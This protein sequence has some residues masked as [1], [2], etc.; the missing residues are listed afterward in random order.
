[1]AEMIITIAADVNDAVRGLDKVQSEI[2]QTGKSAAALSNSVSKAAGSFNRLPQSANQANQAITN[3]NR[4]VQDAPFGFVGIQ[5][6][7]G[8]LIDSF[9]QLKTTTG[10][11]GGALRALLGSLAG[12]AGIGLAIAGIT[13][14]LT[15]A[16]QGFSSWTRGLGAA[17][18]ANDKLAESL[19]LD[20]VRLTSIVG[21]A[22]NA[23]ASTED[24]AKA[25]KLLNQ[26]YAKYLPSLDK[27]AITLEN[28]SQKYQVLVDAMLRQA[29]VKGLQE[30]IA[31]QVEE[32]AKQVTALELAREKE[33]LQLDKGN[34]TKFVS[35][36]T[37]QRL[38]QIAN[39]KNKAISDGVIAYNK[40]A[41][42]ERAAIG[43]TNVYEMMVASLKAQLMESLQPALNL[44]NAFGDLNENLNKTKEVKIGKLDLNQFLQQEEIEIPLKFPGDYT[45]ISKD[46]S[47]TAALI[48]KAM[49]EYFKRTE[50][51][52]ASLLLA[53][54][55]EKLK[56][57]EFMGFKGLT[58]AQKDLAETGNMIANML[59]PSLDA[60]I[61]AVSRGEN[62]FEAFGQ[63]VKAVLV[64][65]IQKLAATAVLAGILSAIFPG[66]L[67]GA[68]GF[69]AIF[70][71]LAG[72]RATGGPVSGGSP[73]VVGERG[74]ELF[75]PA[76]SG[77]I[78][79]N[80]AVGSFM[81]GRSNGNGSGMSV[82][83]GQ[84]ILLAY[85]R[86]QRSQL[87]VNG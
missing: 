42:A 53:L 55:A 12:P 63:G 11:T 65:V 6:N 77:S 30:T 85:A 29:V 80:N 87:R 14:A 57:F 7:I 21:L 69:S 46:V 58:Q 16:I 56:K 8:P 26:E 1:M 40:Q 18:E 34:K 33:R 72:F 71:R 32:T 68:Q 4:V 52:D 13:S 44:A 70:G 10:T 5:N 67:G 41:Q 59:T 48:K 43:T 19:S 9:G 76:V 60:M 24:R 37:D 36:T 78:V 17:K 23:T 49:Q 74:P 28:V 82:L 3:L 20:L 47:P 39:D 38:A 81:S 2:D 22:Q 79:P 64:Q 31:K 62:A 75:V 27:E 51:L 25:I 54:D 84:D 66:G 45:E 50:P 15:F 61:Q 86:T 73:Y 83:R 35:L